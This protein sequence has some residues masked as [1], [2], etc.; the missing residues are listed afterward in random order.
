M[1]FPWEEDAELHEHLRDNNP[2]RDVS[3]RELNRYSY[4]GGSEV[5]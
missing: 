2:F 5:L 3:T 1:D 4:R